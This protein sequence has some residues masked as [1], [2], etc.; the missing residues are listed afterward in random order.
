MEVFGIARSILYVW[1]PSS[2]SA[3]LI[4][5]DEEFGGRIK[6]VIQDFKS[7]VAQQKEPPNGYFK[8]KYSND[9]VKM[10]DRSL[11][12]MPLFIDVVEIVEDENK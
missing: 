8:R 4:H 9:C 5:R 12:K 7:F 11:E 3:W 10:M 1:T 2:S 6:E